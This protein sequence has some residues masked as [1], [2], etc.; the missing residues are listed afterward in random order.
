MRQRNRSRHQLL[1]FVTRESKHHSLVAGAAGVY[2]HG[3]VAGLLID[4]GNDSA[5]VAVEAVEGIVV[6]DALDG[7]A[8]HVLKVD[9]S[10]GRDFSGDDYQSGCRESFAGDSAAGIFAKAG[11]EDGVRDLI[12]DFVGMAFGD[13]LGGEQVAIFWSQMYF[14][15][16]NLPIIRG[17]WVWRERRQVAHGSLR[18]EEAFIKGYQTLVSC[19]TI[20]A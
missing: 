4:S 5:G 18:R 6:S 9:V 8:D 16:N 7:A 14:S 12:C 11:V 15:F 19:A 2:A 13:R 1:G 17:L 20:L 3:D 10:F